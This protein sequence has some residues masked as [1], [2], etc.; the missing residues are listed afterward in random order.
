MVFN[1]AY[2]TGLIS[3]IKLI[4]S[5][6]PYMVKYM[7]LTLKYMQVMIGL[8]GKHRVG[9]GKLLLFLFPKQVT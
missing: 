4:F 6:V 7:L 1:V 5:Y 2:C 9:I 8:L 3:E